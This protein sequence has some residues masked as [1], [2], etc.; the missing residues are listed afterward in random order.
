MAKRNATHSYRTCRDPHCPRFI[1]QVFR[2][3]YDDGYEDGFG[4]GFSA[5]Q[6]EAGE[7][8]K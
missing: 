7:G 4:A 2:E 3:G 1:C 8:S 6:A 5:G